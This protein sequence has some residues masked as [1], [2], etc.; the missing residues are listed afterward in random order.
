[1]VVIAEEIMLETTLSPALTLRPLSELD[2][3]DSRSIMLPM[4]ITPLDAWNLMTAE[5][6]PFMHVAFKIR[7]AISSVFGVKRINGF[8]GIGHES[9]TVGQRLDFFLV[10]HHTKD[11]L[12]LTA[13]DRHLDVML[14]L[15]T[16]GRRL[17]ITSSV[18]VHNAF[19]SLYMLPVGL[20]HKIIVS[21]DLRRLK[22]TLE[23]RHS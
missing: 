15:S 12:A 14:C 13:R 11:T 1:M 18:I 20:A 2:Y 9:V 8:S 23:T 4:A 10:E 21:C 22:R 3:Y 19:G 17:T 7:D 16:E 6:R 5:P